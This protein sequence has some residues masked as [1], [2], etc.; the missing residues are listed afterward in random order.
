MIQPLT[1]RQ[2][3]ESSILLF[4]FVYVYLFVFV[5]KLFVFSLFSTIFQYILCR[6]VSS[7]PEK[8]QHYTSYLRTKHLPGIEEHMPEVTELQMT[9]T[10]RHL[11]RSSSFSIIHFIIRSYVK[12]K[13]ALHTAWNTIV[14]VQFIK[15]CIILYYLIMVYNLK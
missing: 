8:N 6:R 7:Y 11:R 15:L 12:Y 10:N 2:P 9:I 5:F 3:N 14:L 1:N 4:C 13:Y